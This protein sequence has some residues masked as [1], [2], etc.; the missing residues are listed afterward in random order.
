MKNVYH[1]D[2]GL[3]K[4][5]DGRANPTSKTAQFNTTGFMSF[6]PRSFAC[7]VISKGILPF[8]INSAYRNFIVRF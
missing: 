5:T 6:K 7:L 3:N 4:L 2:R 8:E 1:I